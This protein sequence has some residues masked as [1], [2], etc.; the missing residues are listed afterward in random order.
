MTTTA[1]DLGQGSDPRVTTTAEDLGGGSD[2]RVTTTAEDLGGAD[3][4]WTPYEEAM[5]WTIQPAVLPTTS[6]GLGDRNLA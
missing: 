6:L 1:E 2:P 4:G 3:T 5:D